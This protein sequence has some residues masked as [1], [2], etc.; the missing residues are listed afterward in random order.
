MSFAVWTA[1]YTIMGVLGGTM[2]YYRFPRTFDDKEPHPLPDVL[3]EIIPER[4]PK[5][6]GQNIQ[7][8][9]LIIF[10]AYLSVFVVP[11]HPRGLTVLHHFLLLNSLMF[12]TRTT[13][14]SVT[15]L[16]QPNFTPKCLRA[17]NDTATLRESF[18][19]VMLSGFP[20]KAC[21]DL[22]YSGHAACAILSMLIFER[23]GCFFGS[24]AI[25]AAG[26]ALVVAAVASIFMCRSHYTVDVVLGVYFSYFL[27]EWFWA[28]VTGGMAEGSGFGRWVRWL[29][30]E[31]VGVEARGWEESG[32]SSR[33]ESGRSTGEDTA[34]NGDE[35]RT[36]L[37]TGALISPSPTGLISL[38]GSGLTD[39]ASYGAV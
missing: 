32:K 20:P 16:P 26:W 14:V 17:Q 37:L 36:Q 7:S 35:D 1:S 29:T 24:G 5:I 12:L 28:R 8:L 31:E 22:I 11:Y 30:G 9:S 33:A 23:H 39:V 18:S 38:N 34:E 19:V 21:G 27:S 13:T 3:F 10:Y 25:R 4:C 6:L 15:N 2:A